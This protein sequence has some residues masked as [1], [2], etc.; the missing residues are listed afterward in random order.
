MPSRRTLLA[1]GAGAALAAAAAALSWRAREPA[2][3]PTFVDAAGRSVF[4]PGQVSRI[5]AAGPPASMLLYA[6]AP[7]KMLGWARAPSDAAKA[8]LA[9]PYRDL[10][11]YGMLTGRGNTA[12]LEQVISLAPDMILDCGEIDRTYASLADRVQR[13]TGVPYVQL[14]GAFGE[15]ARTLRVMG[16]LL[17]VDEHAARLANYAD[18]VTRAIVAFAQPS[19]KRARIYYGRGAEGLETGRR[20]SL[21]TELIELVAENVAASAGAG[22]L[23]N[24]S[25]E[26]ILLWNPDIIIA[27]DVRFRDALYADGRW[28]SLRAV[29]ERRV[30]VQPSLPFGWIDSPPGVNRLLGALWLRSLLNDDEAGD[31]LRTSVRAFYDLFYHVRLSDPQMDVLLMGARN[32]R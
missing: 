9:T 14:N 17:G 16:K 8:Y 1:L 12:S 21:T 29:R 25:P 18:D 13:Q 10:P 5:F 19:R 3:S 28:I 26:Q 23:T 4:V 30:F 31:V 15:T 20:G 22:G 11:A 24:V 32:G 2:V 27:Q 7:E 6:V